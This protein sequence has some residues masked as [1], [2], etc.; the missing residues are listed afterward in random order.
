MIRSRTTTQTAARRKG[1]IPPRC[2]RGSTFRRA[3]RSD[4]LSSSTT[5]Q[6]NR[7]SERVTLN[8]FAKNA[9]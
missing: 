8:P 6:K 9:R 2:P 1:Y 5:S 7:T 3:E 4:A